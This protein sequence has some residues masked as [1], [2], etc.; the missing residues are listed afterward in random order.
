[1]KRAIVTSLICLLTITSSLSQSIY[2]K[3]LVIN[4]DTLVAVTTLQLK[5]INKFLIERKIYKEAVAESNA[6]MTQYLQDIAIANRL[7]DDKTKLI[8]L[9]SKQIIDLNKLNLLSDKQVDLMRKEIS[10]QKR[11]KFRSTVISITATALVTA[12]TMSLLK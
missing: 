12:T 2:P 8:T 6:K 5:G 1:M 4:G 9:Q 3:K 7:S 11:K 10:N